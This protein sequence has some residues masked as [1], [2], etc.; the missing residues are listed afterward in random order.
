MIRIDFD[1]G[2]WSSRNLDIELCI[3][4]WNIFLQVNNNKT[5]TDIVVINGLSVFYNWYQIW[6]CW[7][8]RKFILTDALFKDHKSWYRKCQITNFWYTCKGLIRGMNVDWKEQSH[9]FND[10]ALINTISMDNIHSE[11]WKLATLGDPLWLL[12]DII[13]LSLLIYGMHQ[14]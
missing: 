12:K 9:Y 10:V 13:N 8:I 6:F 14:P 5:N 1:S 4:F 3:S 7:N 11:V 2:K